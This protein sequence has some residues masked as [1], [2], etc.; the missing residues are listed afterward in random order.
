MMN[1]I[2]EWSGVVALVAIILFQAFG[3]SA[4]NVGGPSG[5]RYP[6]GISAD[7]TSPVAGQVRGTTLSITGASILGGALTA[8]AGALTQGGGVRATSTV[9]TAETLLASDFD[10]ENTID[11]TF[12][13]AVAGGTVTL[14]ASTT[15]PLSTTPGAMRTIW[16]RNATSTAATVL[17]IAGN[18]GT[19]LK[20][21]STSPSS[22][23]ILGDTDAGNYARLDFLR[24]ANSDIEVFLQGYRD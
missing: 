4:G 5:T 2:K 10:T 7:T 9:N 17:T 3:P 13:G 24:K 6:N 21:A 14:P 22:A 18:T 23:G 19:L 12:N 20:I 11:Y 1:K 8:D 16:V 15:L